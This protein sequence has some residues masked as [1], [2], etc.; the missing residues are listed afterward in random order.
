MEGEILNFIKVWIS[1]LVS[2]CF[3]YSIRNVVPKGTKRLLSVLPVVCLFLYLPLKIS[4][5]HLG[6]STAFFIA[7]LA[8]F[9]VLLF[10]FGKGPLSSD[11]SISLP[12]FIALACLPIKIQQKDFL[13]EILLAVGAVLARNF[14]GLELEPQFNEPYLATSLQDFWGCR[15]NLVVTSILRPTVYEPTRAIGSHL[16][17]RKWAPLP[18]VFATFVVSAIMHEIIFYYLGRVRPNW[19]ISWFFLLHGFCLT[20]EI[21]LKKVL[22]DRWRLPK[23]ISTMLTVGFVMSTGFWLFFPKFVEYKVDVRAFEEYAEIGA[24]MKNV[25]QSIVRVLPGH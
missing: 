25:S 16:I 3:C 12:L 15:W 6:G 19:E 9:K 1:V 13:L 5:V 22:N 4:S 7:W 10:A 18:A 2:L 8:N 21:A 24:Y 23:M 14:L 20:V 17:G 11:P